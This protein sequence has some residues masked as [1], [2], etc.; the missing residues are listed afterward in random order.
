MSAHKEIRALTGLRG[1]AALYVV[2]FHYTDGLAPTNPLNILI[3]HGYLAVDIFFVLSGFVMAL[4]YRHLFDGTP[5]WRA[6]ITFLG[7]RIARVYPLYLCGTLVGYLLVRHIA[8][9]PGRL[10]DMRHAPILNFLMMQSWFLAPSLDAP[11]WS[12]SAE[13]A[14]YLVF[15]ALLSLCFFRPT[16]RH[17]LGLAC[18]IAAVIAFAHL[19]QLLRHHPTFSFSNDF[20][21]IN[22]NQV[23][24]C[25]PEFTLGIFVVRGLGTP[26]GRSLEGIFVAHSWTVSLFSLGLVALLMVAG[27]ELLFVLLLPLLLLSLMPTSTLPARL[28]SSGPVY[29]FGLISYS[30]YI[31]HGLSTQVLVRVHAWAQSHHL[32]HA[33]TYAAL[34][35]FTLVVPLSILTYYYIELPASRLLRR[36]FE[37]APK[38]KE[39]PGPCLPHKFPI[40]S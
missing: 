16:F 40:E 35:A 39:P 8:L 31:V 14:A 2:L 24:R 21:D 17:W 27:K 18:C 38:P 6:Y 9:D 13:W 28:L 30:L 25:L 33:Q 37:G 34:T 20:F 23:L 36:W 3:G 15:P 32:Q 5:F 12:L 10:S 19:P 4:N 11:G 26:L 1:V 22:T 7:R 29:F